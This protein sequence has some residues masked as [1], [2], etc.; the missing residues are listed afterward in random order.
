MRRLIAMATLLAA[1]AFPSMAFGLL[2]DDLKITDH[3]TTCAVTSVVS[4]DDA[5]NCIGKLSGLGSTTTYI[6]VS[7]DFTCTNKAGNTVVGQA[8]GSS[9]PIS[10]DQGQVTFNVYTASADNVG[11]CNHADGHY[12]TW[13]AN[14]TIDVLQ[15]GK[16]VFSEQCPLSGGGSCVTTFVAPK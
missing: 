13:G 9:G 5:V 7:A 3:G 15:N 6:Q 10:P 4:T 8:G 2:G 14:A 11:Q 12:A 16:L 1:V